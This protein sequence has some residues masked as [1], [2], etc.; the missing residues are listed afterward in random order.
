MPSEGRTGLG[1]RAQTLFYFNSF[2]LFLASTASLSPFEHSLADVRN[3][4]YS[5][6]PRAAENWHVPRSPWSR[7]G[8]TTWPLGKE[9]GGGTTAFWKQLVLRSWGCPGDSTATPHFLEQFWLS[10]TLNRKDRE[11]QPRSPRPL[12]PPRQVSLSPRGS[13]Q[14]AVTPQPRCPGLWLGV[15]SVALTNAEWHMPAASVTEK[16]CSVTSGWLYSR[17]RRISQQCTPFPGMSAQLSCSCLFGGPFLP[18][19]CLEFLV[20]SAP[21]GLLGTAPPGWLGLQSKLLMASRAHS[22]CLFMKPCFSV[23]SFMV[24]AFGADPKNHH[25]T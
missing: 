19:R 13:R 20:H 25:Q 16:V 10:K 5:L 3:S 15:H 24:H 7:G 22:C 17:Y 14:T 11:P 8:R 23:L 9:L 21:P 12:R 4:E 18:G 2:E 6:C 1:G